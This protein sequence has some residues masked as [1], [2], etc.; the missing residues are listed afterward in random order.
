MASLESKCNPDMDETKEA[1]QKWIDSA[2]AWIADMRKGDLNRTHLLD[3][4]L[5]KLA[6]DVSGHKVIDIGC[7]EGRFSRM[8]AD[9]GAEVT[10]ID[11]TGPLIEEARKLQPE[12]RYYEA[13]AE[14]LPFANSSFDLAVSYL[15]LIDVPD[16]RLAI[17]EMVRVVR[18]GGRILA[19][20]LNSFVSTA[21]GWHRDSERKKLHYPVDQYFEERPLRLE[22]AGISILN[23]HRPLEAYMTA[24]LK[25][26]LILR[27]FLEPQPTEAAIAD[28]PKMADGARIPYFNV[29]VWEKP[30]S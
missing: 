18:P 28:Q 14:E 20:N 24:Y 19:A 30:H 26:G 8:L 13:S 11:L 21:S 5:L 15:V 22:W 7:G 4:V 6:G 25:E 3:S 1:K 10:G 12:G 2:P 29:M 17:K 9:G 23:W 27:H 16:F